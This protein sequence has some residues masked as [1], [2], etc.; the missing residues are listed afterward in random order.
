MCNTNKN[1]KNTMLKKK[2]DI[3][4]AKTIEIAHQMIELAQAGYDQ[5]EDDNCGILYGIMLD[6]GYQL[7]DLAKKEKHAHTKKGW[8][9]QSINNSI[10]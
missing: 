4:V 7:L 10:E 8:W 3:N 5:R 6:S 1:T 9:K 2:C